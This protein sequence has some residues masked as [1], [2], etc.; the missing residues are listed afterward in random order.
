MLLIE[1]S[2]M[3]SYMIFT[4]LLQDTISK[5]KKR[6]EAIKEEVGAAGTC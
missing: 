5:S 2:T 3:W 4:S 6:I 1:L